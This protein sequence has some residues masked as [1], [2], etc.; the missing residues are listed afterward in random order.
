VKSYLI[1]QNIA[2]MFLKLPPAFDSLQIAH[3]YLD[4][5]GKQQLVIP[6]EERWTRAIQGPA[7]HRDQGLERRF[8]YFPCNCRPPNFPTNP[9][10]VLSIAIA[11]IPVVIMSSTATVTEQPTITAANVQHLFPEVNTSV[12]GGSHDSARN[13]DAL[14]GYDEEQI[15]LMD[16][17]CIVL[18]EDDKPIGSASKK[19]CK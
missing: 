16:E 15:K 2:I 5:G 4:Y 1:A 19:V 14:A 3:D 18:D 6:A 8:L 13:D 11:Q 7:R 17:V 10:T 9:L 12:I